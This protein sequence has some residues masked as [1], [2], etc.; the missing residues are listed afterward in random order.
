VTA[1]DP[2]GR[3]SEAPVRTL[4]AQDLGVTVEE[5]ITEH[6][7]NDPDQQGLAADDPVLVRVL[8]LLESYGGVILA[9]PPGTSKSWYAAKISSVLVEGDEER[10]RFVQFHPSYQY[11][12]FMQGFVPSDEGFV[13]ADA[14]FVQMCRAALADPDR[15]Y[16]LVIDELSRGDPGRVFGEALTYLEKSK[17]G[18]RFQLASGDHLVVPPNLHLIATMNPNDRGVDEVDAAFERRFARVAM[19]PDP[20]ILTGMLEAN[21][22]D[23]NLIRRLVG[24]FRLVNGQARTNPTMAIGH[25]Y[26]ADSATADDLQRVWDHQLRFVFERAFRLNQPGLQEIENR[27]AQTLQLPTAPASAEQEEQGIE[28][29]RRANGEPIYSGSAAEQAERELRE[30]TAGNGAGDGDSTGRS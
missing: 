8:S 17:R 18:L 24:F 12:D 23:P 1:S 14:H 19:D 30:G 6:A 5:A 7:S 21:E 27:W 4:T 9:G 13:R 22:M 11:E 16:V 10:R 26:F 15:R 28:V 20:D 3:W 29:G 2:Q 25:T